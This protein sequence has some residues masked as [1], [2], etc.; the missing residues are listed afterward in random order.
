MPAVTA[1][2]KNEV[3]FL[4]MLRDLTSV[5][6]QDA[7]A[8]TNNDNIAQRIGGTRKKPRAEDRD[9]TVQADLE[10]AEDK[11]SRALPDMAPETTF[12]Y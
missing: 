6:D 7:S 2:E 4:M 8:V 11:Y 3:K 12:L 5:I 10:A 1:Q 9:S